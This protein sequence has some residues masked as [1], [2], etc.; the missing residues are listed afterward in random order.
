MRCASTSKCGYAIHVNVIRHLIT[1]CSVCASD[2]VVIY[3]KSTIVCKLGLH[4]S[5]S[6][7]STQIQDLAVLHRIA[8]YRA[9]IEVSNSQSVVCQQVRTVSGQT[10]TRLLSRTGMDLAHIW[11]QE[12]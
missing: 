11:Q 12:N 2:F 7:A 10:C 6:P 3:P 4:T 5:S 8:L 9:H 1:L